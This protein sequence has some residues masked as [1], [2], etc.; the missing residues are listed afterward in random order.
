MGFFS[1][2]TQRL[3]LLFLIILLKKYAMKLSDQCRSMLNFYLEYFYF[4]SKASIFIP[5]L[6]LKRNHDI[7]LLFICGLNGDSSLTYLR[8]RLLCSSRTFDACI[9]KL[10]D[11][12]FIK[13]AKDKKD[14]RVKIVSLTEKS[15][16][17]LEQI[18]EA[19]KKVV[20]KTL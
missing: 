9:L 5:L 15:C 14:K 20:L 17:G 10:E 11:L 18:T 8:S 3:R 16:K 1:K 12:K 13:V 7:A 2:Y 4:A 19:G 6:K